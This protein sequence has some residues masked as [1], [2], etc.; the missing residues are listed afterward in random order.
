MLEFSHN[1]DTLCV[2]DRFLIVDDWA[3]DVVSHTPQLCVTVPYDPTNTLGAIVPLLQAS[4]KGLYHS[5]PFSFI[6][7]QSSR[8]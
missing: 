6:I 2:L 8:P 1:V 4:G 5:F 7:T 3:G